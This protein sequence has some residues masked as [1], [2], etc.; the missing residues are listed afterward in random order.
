M[1]LGPTSTPMPHSEDPLLDLV[2]ASENPSTD[3]ES[4]SRLGHAA[5]LAGETAA[6]TSTVTKPSINQS[7]LGRLALGG[8]GLAVEPEQE[9]TVKEKNFF[10]ES[11]GDDY[12]ASTF[13]RQ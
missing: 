6:M 10:E 2:I 5:L 7:A 1:Q 3:L 8:L 4:L 9:P 12:I 13:K 11:S